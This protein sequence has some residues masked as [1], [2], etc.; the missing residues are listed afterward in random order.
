MDE[1]SVKIRLIPELEEISDS[2]FQERVWVDNSVPG[3]RSS[4]DEC[5]EEFMEISRSLLAELDEN[6]PEPPETRALRELYHHIKEFHM[7]FACKENLAD[8][9]KSLIVHPEWIKIQKEAASLFHFLK[10][11]Y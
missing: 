9:E 4:Y 8:D 5:I 7:N 6:E 3:K 1:N 10:Q 2:D 11:M